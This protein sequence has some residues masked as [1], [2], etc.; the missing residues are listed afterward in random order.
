ME[1]PPGE[2]LGAES[3]VSEDVI[4][5]RLPKAGSEVNFLTP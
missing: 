2:V 4:F 3:A 1:R 5:N